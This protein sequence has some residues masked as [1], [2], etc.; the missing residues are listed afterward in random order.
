MPDD[1]AN[2]Y[3]EYAEIFMRARN[4]KIGPSVMRE[5]ASQLAPGSEVLELGCGHGVVSQ[6]LLETGV[7]LSVV[8][9]SPTLLRRFIAD[10]LMSKLSARQH[11]SPSCSV[12]NMAAWSRGA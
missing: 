11:K 10:F 6:V 1:G 3:E 2:G 4:S 9:A 12:V 8:D 7:K 5:W